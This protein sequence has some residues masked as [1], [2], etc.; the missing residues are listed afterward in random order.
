[1]ERFLS[2]RKDNLKKGDG[3]IVGADMTQEWLL[4]WWFRK[5]RQNNNDPVTFVDFGMSFEKKQWCKQN[6]ELISLRIFADFVKEK[7][8]IDPKTSQFW[9]N[10][11]G[12]HCWES[13]SSWFKKPLA[14][15]QSP[16]ERT[17]WIDLDCEVRASIKDLF[18]YADQPSRFSMAKDQVPAIKGVNY[19][20]YNSGVIA[21]MSNAEILV[22]WAKSCLKKNHVLR[23]DQEVFSALINEKKI[24]FKKIPQAYNFS[25][26][27]EEKEACKILHWHGPHG[28]QVIRTMIQLEELP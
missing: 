8:E 28:K 13:R 1:M 20:I 2:W 5:F 16:Y 27:I 18:D 24:S 4:P 10:E 12:S 21:Y 25:R 19:P 22:E 11:F 26:T 14:C 6:G 23:G 9:E 3:V 17:L 15:L 7:D